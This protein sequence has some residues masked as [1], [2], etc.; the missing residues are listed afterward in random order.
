MSQDQTQPSAA[1]L[2]YT[3]GRERIFFRNGLWHGLEVRAEDPTTLD[4]V[5][6][7]FSAEQWSDIAN[8]HGRFLGMCCATISQL[9]D[10]LVAALHEAGWISMDA[11]REVIVLARGHDLLPRT[12]AEQDALNPWTLLARV[13]EAVEPYAKPAAASGN[14]LRNLANDP[15]DLENALEIVSL[16]AARL[17]YDTAFTT[18]ADAREACGLRLNLVRLLP[19]LATVNARVAT[20]WPGDFTGVA[21]VWK[22]TPDHIIETNGGPTLYATREASEETLRWWRRTDPEVDA[23]VRFRP[24]RVTLEKGLEFLDEAE[25][26]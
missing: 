19:A 8:R 3:F 5:R 22:A 16:L 20:L 24:V 1:D 26:T 18:E 14:S 2:E 10:L 7:P 12:A 9:R 21:L 23:K 4:S 15:R 13:W 25:A 11:L 17:A 6:L